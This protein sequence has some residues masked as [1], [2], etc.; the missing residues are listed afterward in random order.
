MEQG[1]GKTITTLEIARIRYESGKIE[2]VIWLCPCSAKENIKREILK[3]CPLDLSRI[4]T[5]CGIETLSTSI[6]ANEY[7]LALANNRK[8]FLVVDESLLVKNPAAYRTINISRI[9]ET[10]LYHIS[11]K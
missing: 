10:S 7:L 6:R 2:A 11:L 5:I 4:F 1:T 9:S 3:Q 8:C